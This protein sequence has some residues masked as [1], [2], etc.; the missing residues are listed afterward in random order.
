MADP[1]L[2]VVG[3]AGSFDW[4]S[5]FQPSSHDL[6]PRSAFSRIIS[7]LRLISFGGGRYRSV[8]RRWGRSFWVAP[9]KSLTIGESLPRTCF[10]LKSDLLSR[11][12]F[13]L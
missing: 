11:N 4:K 9:R 7:R 2:L 10:A 13:A 12:S 6:G 1:P 5:T 3:K 8:E